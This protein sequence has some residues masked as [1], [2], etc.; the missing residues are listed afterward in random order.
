MNIRD[1]IDTINGLKKAAD[2]LEN[3]RG[4]KLAEQCRKAVLI[5]EGQKP[6]RKERVES[7]Y[8]DIYV[9]SYRCP[10]CA[11][12]IEEEDLY[13]RHCGRAVLPVQMI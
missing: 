2:T 12:P 9:A 1:T 13:C 10:E 4:D 7:Y 8:G 6:I 11:K 3:L 5:I